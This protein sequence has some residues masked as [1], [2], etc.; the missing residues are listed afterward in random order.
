MSYKK[1][2]GYPYSIVSMS[3]IDIRKFENRTKNHTFESLG[4]E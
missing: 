1:S 4:H 2:I 3:Q